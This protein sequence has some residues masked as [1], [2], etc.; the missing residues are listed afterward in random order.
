MRHRFH[1][2]NEQRCLDNN[3]GVPFAMAELEFVSVE[4]RDL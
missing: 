1:R 3:H 2:H 4:P